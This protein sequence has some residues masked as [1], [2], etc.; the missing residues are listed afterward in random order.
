MNTE[1][2][3]ETKEFL[4]SSSSSAEFPNGSSFPNSN[5]FLPSVP[6]VFN[7]ITESCS[8]LAVLLRIHREAASADFPL[9]SSGL[10]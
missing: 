3:K 6:S 2:T 7:L 1:G 9:V 8:K 5:S 10:R 4:I